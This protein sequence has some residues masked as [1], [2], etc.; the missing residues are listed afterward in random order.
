MQ[1]VVKAASKKEAASIAAQYRQHGVGLLSGTRTT[2]ELRRMRHPFA[3]AHGSIQAV[4][5]K[6]GN[7]Y[8]VSATNARARATAGFLPLLPINRQSGRLLQAFR[9]VPVSSGDGYVF[10]V[11]DSVPYALYQIDPDNRGTR[12]MLPR[13]FWKAFTSLKP[14]FG[15]AVLNAK[16]AAEK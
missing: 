9:V 1:R 3:R 2:R 8:R 6:T 13:G 15:K 14:R 16:R 12:R 4:S 5:G 11:R 10:F 7:I